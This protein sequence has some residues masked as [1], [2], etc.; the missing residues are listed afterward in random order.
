MAEESLQPI[1]GMSD[2]AAP[3]ICLWH[4][5]EQTAR[6]IMSAYAFQEV[7]TP[8]VEQTAVFTRSLGDTTDIVQKEMYRVLD[9][10]GRELT[11]RPEGTAGVMRHVS[12]LGQD[13]A[14]ARL[15]YLGPMFRAERPAAGRRRQF[16]QLGAEAIGPATAM[17]DA[18]MIALQAH[19]LEAW[20]IKDFVVHL[21]TRGAPDDFSRVTE[22]LRAALAGQ[23]HTLCA[24]CQRRYNE[25]PL[26][27]LDCKVEQCAEQVAALPPITE[28]MG[29][30][31]NAYVDE[32]LAWLERLN[33]PAV[34]NP[35]LVRGL[36]YYQHTVWEVT[37]SGLGAQDALSGGGRY[38]LNMAGRPV[39]GV[40]FAIGLERVIAVLKAQGLVPE[41][42]MP[43]PDVFVV[44]HGDRAA[45]ENLVLMQSLR[46]RGIAALMD[47]RGRS[48]KAQM[49]AANRSRSRFVI[50]R[51][52]T[53]LAAGTFQ[54]KDMDAGSQ[55]ELDMPAL[56]NRLL[57]GP[58][59]AVA[60]QA[61]DE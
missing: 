11:L 1:R 16:H 34:K 13:G 40:G 55:A 20:G 27:I 23:R 41:S 29:A 6:D 18:E 7:R 38:A 37:H 3:E 50:I 9:R 10:G 19:V 44:S 26:R 5:L 58:A 39:E 8:L 46:L 33:I 47:V 43:R 22:A 45:E 42:M 14:D 32:V 15:Y 61:G 30:P 17:A 36:D 21:N 51:G 48:V 28:W 2:L 59:H 31:A 57:P 35:R 60:N 53:E 49:R 24:D 54:F 25:N 52:D 4:A 12:G 56:M